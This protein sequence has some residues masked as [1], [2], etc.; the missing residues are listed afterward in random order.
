MESKKID[1]N[2][3]GM[4][5]KKTEQGYKR[6]KYDELRKVLKLKHHNL[7]QAN[8]GLG[9]I[10]IPSVFSGISGSQKWVCLLK[11]EKTHFPGCPKIGTR[12]C[13]ESLDMLI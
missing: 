12:M 2:K 1:L 11:D 10:L 7:I 9:N 5:I 3:R 13:N 6:K 4:K 8:D